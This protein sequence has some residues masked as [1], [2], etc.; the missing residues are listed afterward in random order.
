M[1][2]N[3][4]NDAI[5]LIKKVKLITILGIGTRNWFVSKHNK[6]EI[7]FQI[8]IL[9]EDF[10]LLLLLLYRVCTKTVLNLLININLLLLIE[11]SEGIIKMK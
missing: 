4:K 5:D 10:I 2:N 9:I 7:I 6:D 3:V 11:N 1:T 8:S